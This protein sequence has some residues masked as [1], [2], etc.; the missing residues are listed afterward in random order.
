[1]FDGVSV[2]EKERGSVAWDFWSFWGVMTANVSSKIGTIQKRI[3]DSFN[4]KNTTLDK[5][6]NK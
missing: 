2:T 6:L 3:I 1:M 4:N 5:G